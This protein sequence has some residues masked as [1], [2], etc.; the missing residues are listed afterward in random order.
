MIYFC[1]QKVFCKNTSILYIY[2]YLSAISLLLITF[3][4]NKYLCI[5]KLH[6]FEIS[7]SSVELP[8]KSGKQSNLKMCSNQY[9]S[10]ISR[11]G[12]HRFYG[13]DF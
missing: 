10:I 2:I 13:S 9:E 11:H 12:I 4:R 3:I 1:I 6:W 7:F 8:V 5:Y